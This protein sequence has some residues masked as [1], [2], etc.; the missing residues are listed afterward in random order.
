[1][2]L[3]RYMNRK[4]CDD[5]VHRGVVRLTKSSVCKDGTGMTEMQ[6]DDENFKSLDFDSSQIYEV[7]DKTEID[8]EPEIVKL[9]E[10]P[11]GG[12]YGISARVKCPY[13]MYCL[14]TDLRLDLF[15]TRDFKCDAAVI[16]RDA[17]EL[18]RR[19]ALAA[20]ALYVHPHGGQGGLW[21][22]I[23]YTSP[24]TIHYGRSLVAISPFF[25]KPDRYRHQKEFRFALYPCYD[26]QDYAYIHL[27]N[28]EGICDVVGKEDLERGTV[29]E[30]VYNEEL[31]H[32]GAKKA[33][34]NNGN[35]MLA[36]ILGRRIRNIVR[37]ED[38][39]V[40]ITDEKTY[41][42]TSLRVL[43]DYLTEAPGGPRLALD[44][45]D[46]ESLYEAEQICRRPLFPEG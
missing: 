6:M 2:V 7:V 21:Q 20:S 23:S 24:R 22:P 31:F 19:M 1:M 9:A 44:K 43:L 34:L 40:R 14:S 27:G 45:I 11:E 25:T 16:I 29:E 46:L 32:D 36:K 5:M 12:T 37:G 35:T 41:G 18:F 39:V 28:L 30:V 38:G 17:E 33:L 3:F 4:Y 15:E 42:N 10:S 26:A 8:V 13:W